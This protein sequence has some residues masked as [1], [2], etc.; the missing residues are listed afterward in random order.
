MSSTSNSNGSAT[1]T[2]T[3]KT[4]TDIDKAQMDVQNKLALVEQRLPEQVRRQ[5]IPVQKANSGFL[6]LIAVGSNSGRTGALE[7]GNFANARVVDELRRVPGVGNV[8]V[9]ASPYAMR[10]WLDQQKLANKSE[11]RRVGKTWFSKCRSRGEP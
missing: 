1:I 9:F 7:L 6:L 5:G 8:Q 10:L 4:G 11:E 3:F 2:I